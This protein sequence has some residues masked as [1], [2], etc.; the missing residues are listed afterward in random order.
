MKQQRF[1]ATYYRCLESQPQEDD[2]VP[3]LQDKD[4]KR[5]TAKAAAW[6]RKQLASDADAQEEWISSQLNDPPLEDRPLVALKEWQSIKDW[7]TK[8]EGIEQRDT[9]LLSSA[10][11]DA[12]DLGRNSIAAEGHRR[13]PDFGLYP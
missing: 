3:S 5:L 4:G 13:V 10:V 2:L 9:R 7:I 6:L 1:L 8:H 12:H 11:N